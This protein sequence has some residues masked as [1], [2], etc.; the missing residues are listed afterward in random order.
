MVRDRSEEEVQQEFVDHFPSGAGNLGFNLWKRTVM[1]HLKWKVYRSLY[2]ESPEQIDLLNWSAPA[3]FALLGDIL[4][5]DVLLAIARLIDPSQTGKWENAS[6]GN[7]IAILPAEDVAKHSWDTKFNKLTC[8]SKDIRT[9]RNKKIAHQDLKQAL[10]Y[11]DDPLP[12]ISRAYVEEVLK[13]TRV[14][15]GD[16][17]NEYLGTRN[18]TEHFLPPIGG[19]DKLIYLLEEARKNSGLK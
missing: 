13:D 10:R 9:L 7:L 3:F 14:L 1:L 16:I 15:L 11:H 2:G 17:E 12:G 6:I 19:V 5:D 4:L 18:T 8:L